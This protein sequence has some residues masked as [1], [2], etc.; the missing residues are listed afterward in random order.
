MAPSWLPLPSILP[1]NIQKRLVSYALTHVLGT[2]LE[3]QTF[4]VEN[5][6]LE[7]LNGNVSLRN[8]DLNAAK[9]NSLLKLPGIEIVEGRVGQVFLQIPVRDVL[10]GKISVRL[11]GI[12]VLVRPCK[13]A[14]KELWILC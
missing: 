9:V 3:H 6:E 10:S 4:D 12:A 2:F 11:S 5:L 8:L 1:S 7:L 14:S 13:E